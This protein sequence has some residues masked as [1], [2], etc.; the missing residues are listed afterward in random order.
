MIKNINDLK[1]KLNRKIITAL[2]LTR[3]DVFNIIYNKVEEYY[4]EPVFEGKNEPNDYI[5][6]NTL[7]DA[8]SATEIIKK[9]NLYSFIVGWPDEY[10]E[11]QYPG[12]KS[13]YGRGST[14][15]NKATGFQILT[16]FNSSRHGGNAFLG[17]H[18]YWDEA[19]DEINGRG[20]LD[21]IFYN[22][23]KQLGVP[24]K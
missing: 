6:T 15:I 21:G 12:W 17:S 18:N 7:Q 24:I 9:D 22:Y 1:S 8:L 20:G 14:G 2:E 11:F 10:L 23:L 13:Q 3:N 4:N 5:R 16:Y 19:L